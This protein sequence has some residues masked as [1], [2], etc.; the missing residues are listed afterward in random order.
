MMSPKNW[1]RSRVWLSSLPFLAWMLPGHA[2][3][4]GAPDELVLFPYFTAEQQS[5]V[6]LM[7]SWD[8]LAFQHVNEGAPIFS[9]SEGVTRDPSIVRGPDGVFHM[10]WTTDPKAIGYANS[11]DLVTWS[12]PRTIPVWGP[13][14]NVINT[15][16]PELYYDETE[17]EF[18]IVWAS[19]D[20]DRFPTGSSE[21]A[22][23]GEGFEHRLYAATTTDFET[24]SQTEL[25]FD[26]G[27][28]V[29]DGMIAHDP[30]GA[31]FV[32]AFKDERLNDEHG[33]PDPRK[34]IAL[35]FSSSAR[36]PWG[37]L[38]GSLTGGGVAITQWAEGSTLLRSEQGWRL[39]Y[40]S[41]VDRISVYHA[42][43]SDDLET[44]TD[45]SNQLAFPEIEGRLQHGT[46]FRV[47]ASDIGW[48]V[49][50]PRASALLGCGAAVLALARSMRRAVRRRVR[51]S[52]RAG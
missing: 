37:D 33:A 23:D 7:A 26:P 42:L 24:L 2:H 40:D 45:I 13:E 1:L 20:R 43:A 12:E 8:G 44:W 14:D 18:L 28:N 32:M 49:P 17:Q 19:T 34:Y 29:I 16:A 4:G 27:F 3:A 48:P 38:G 9:V 30:D 15:W 21:P 5:S 36:G 22:P 46:L 52:V 50:E 51:E 31:R 41:Y 35:A 11:S 6:F 25:F 47:S 39:Y 10:V